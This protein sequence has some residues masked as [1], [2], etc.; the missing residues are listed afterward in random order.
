MKNKNPA[1]KIAKSIVQIRKIRKLSQQQFAT[2]VGIT[3]EM[4]AAYETLHR[5]PR[6]DTILKI[7][8][9]YKISVDDLLSGNI[10]EGKYEK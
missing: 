7:S 10:R 5:E 2:E 3:R 1:N 8:R 9:T 6:L 4:V